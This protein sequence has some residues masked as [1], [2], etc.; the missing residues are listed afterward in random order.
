MCQSLVVEAKIPQKKVIRKFLAKKKETAISIFHYLTPN[1]SDKTT[2]FVITM[3][4][5]HTSDWHLGQVLY[6]YDRT[7]EQTGFLEQLVR[8]VVNEQPDALLVSGDVFHT[9]APA[10]AT[11][12]MYVDAMLELRNACPTMTM[13]V[14]A[15]NHDSAS[16]L[17]SDRKLWQVAG[18]HVVGAVERCEDHSALTEH[19]LFTVCDARGETVGTIVAVPHCYRLPSPSF[20]TDL[21]T[22]ADHRLPVVLMAHL[23]MKDSDTTGHDNIGTLDSV[24]LERVAGYD[25]VAL[26]HIH[27]AQDIKDSQKRVRYC[28]TPLAV[29]FDEKAKHSVSVVTLHGHDGP[30]VRTIEI[31]TDRP[32]QTIPND[33]PLPFCDA[34]Q[35]L[36]EFPD[37]R[38]CYVRL[39]VLLNEPLPIDAYE[40]AA[41]QCAKK[42]YRLCT[43]RTTTP[44]TASL[45]PSAMSVDRFQEMTP[46][47]VANRYV[48]SQLG[49]ELNER[50][51]RMIYETLNKISEEEH[52]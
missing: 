11:V 19:H 18:I 32:L 35:R 24:A 49:R 7:E 17:D 52:T 15:G 13:V 44:N 20:Y 1:F 42:N 36:E 28:G 50:E 21:L 12:R 30:Q 14:I 2:I 51:M 38:Q 39:N 46:I 26:G 37:S 23:T 8:I 45:T 25:Y 34:L 31:E 10:A 22:L 4:I 5:I 9:S 47:D 41:A 43:I 48:T 16:R 6:N 27:H 33:E 40:R 29:S 3:K